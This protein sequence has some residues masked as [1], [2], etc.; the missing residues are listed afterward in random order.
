LPPS[1]PGPRPGRAAAAGVA[2][3]P[4]SNDDDRSIIDTNA[5]REI[6]RGPVG[7]RPHRFVPTPDSRLGR[8]GRRRVRNLVFLDPP[9]ADLVRRV[10]RVPDPYPLGFSLDQQ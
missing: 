7:T 1:W 6:R 5:Y 3:V 2:V 4:N 9:T 10:A 8:G